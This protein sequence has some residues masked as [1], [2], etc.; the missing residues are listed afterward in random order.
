MGEGKVS[1][2]G[3]PPAPPPPLPA[4]AT[5]RSPPA[6][7]STV[8]APGCRRSGIEAFLLRRKTSSRPPK[9]PPRPPPA[10]R[11]SRSL[12]WLGPETPG[13]PGVNPL[14]KKGSGE[15]RLGFFL[16]VSLFIAFTG[17]GTMDL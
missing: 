4:G 12:S 16:S 1:R 10:L 6:A 14:R 15:R 3:V 13:S 9:P 5:A 17:K 7:P 2:G 8:P 11:G